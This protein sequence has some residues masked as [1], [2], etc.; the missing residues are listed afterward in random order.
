MLSNSNLML[1][2]ELSGPK[3]VSILSLSSIPFQMTELFKSFTFLWIQILQ[4]TFRNFVGFCQNWCATTHFYIF[5]LNL[6]NEDWGGGDKNIHF[7][8]GLFT[9]SPKISKSEPYEL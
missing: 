4:D 2:L 3:L 7:W 9:G 1:L 6:R 8:K 5:R